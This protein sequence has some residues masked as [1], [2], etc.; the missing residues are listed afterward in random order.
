MIPYKNY[1]LSLK[2]RK[3]NVRRR[4]FAGFVYY[5]NVKRRII[6]FKIR[7]AALYTGYAYNVCVIYIKLFQRAVADAFAVYSVPPFR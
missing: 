4:A 5:Y 2:H 3:Y 6:V 7:R 1:F